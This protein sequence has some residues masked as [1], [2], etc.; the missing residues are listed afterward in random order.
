MVFVWSLCRHGNASFTCVSY[1]AVQIAGV[2]QHGKMYGLGPMVC[3]SLD[4]ILTGMLLVRFESL[5][6][7]CIKITV[8]WNVM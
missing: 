8:V 4:I 6:T 3:P 5:M 2:V 1:D 7:M